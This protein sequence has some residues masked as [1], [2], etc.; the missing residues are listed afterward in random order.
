MDDIDK[1]I[2]KAAGLFAALRLEMVIQDAQIGQATAIVGEW[3][4]AELKE[5]REENN[6][7]RIVNEALD[8]FNKAIEQQTKDECYFEISKLIKNRLIGKGEKYLSAN[9]SDIYALIQRT[10]GALKSI[11]SAEVKPSGDSA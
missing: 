6:A 5:C 8:N 10:L 11:D 1:K 3:L 9:C 7:L 4:I 2:K